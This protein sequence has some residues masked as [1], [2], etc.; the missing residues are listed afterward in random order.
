VEIISLVGLVNRCIKP[1]CHL[2]LFDYVLIFLIIGFYK[3]L[4]FYVI[5]FYGIFLVL[6]LTIVIRYGIVAFAN[7]RFTIKTSVGQTYYYHWPYN[8]IDYHLGYDSE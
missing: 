6:Y 5:V 4:C 7:R 1:L 2:S 3:I 8:V